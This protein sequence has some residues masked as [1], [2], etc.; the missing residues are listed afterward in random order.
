MSLNC[1][2]V[3]ITQKNVFDYLDTIDLLPYLRKFNNKN[4]YYLM[5][6][7][8][9]LFPFKDEYSES[10]FDAMGSDEFVEYLNNK[11]N[12][13]IHEEVVCSYYIRI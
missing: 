9:E 8:E 7:L 12:L 6:K 11:Y 4:I 5:D 10:L 13:N 3:E 1:K 2:Q